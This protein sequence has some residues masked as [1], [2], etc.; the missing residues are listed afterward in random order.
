MIRQFSLAVLIFFSAHASGQVI[1]SV[2][3]DVG[4]GGPSNSVCNAATDGLSGVGDID[5]EYAQVTPTGL[6]FGPMNF[7]APNIPAGME[8]T[9][10]EIILHNSIC[11]GNLNVSIGGESLM[12]VSNQICFFNQIECP[13]S[14]LKGSLSFNCGSSAS[15]DISFGDVNQFD[16]SREFTGTFDTF[17]FTHAE[18]VFTFNQCAAIPT[19]G[20]WGVLILGLMSMIVGVIGIRQL[21]L[22]RY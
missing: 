14:D 10:L 22:I 6:T 5:Q 18:V 15:T 2:F 9:N 13:N 1:Q 11:P 3:V 16:V 4:G 19:L 7:T 17:I 20:E 8:L 12:I 21:K